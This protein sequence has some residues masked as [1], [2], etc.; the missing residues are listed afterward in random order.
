MEETLRSMLIYKKQAEQYKQE[1]TTLTIAFEVRP[2]V[3]S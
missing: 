3:P 1:K 2:R